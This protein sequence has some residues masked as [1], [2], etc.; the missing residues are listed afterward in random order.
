MVTTADS[1]DDVID[2]TSLERPAPTLGP[3]DPGLH[4]LKTMVKGF[5]L[6]VD[7]RAYRLRNTA[8]EMSHSEVRKLSETRKRID[9]RYTNLYRYSGDDG[10]ASLS[11]L[12][13]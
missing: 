10:L 3:Y 12:T 11:F 13:D 2:L 5:S 7:Y 1:P 9:T 6:L 8:A 4:P